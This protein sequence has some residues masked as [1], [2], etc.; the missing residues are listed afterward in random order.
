MDV[1]CL[2]CGSHWPEKKISN[3][4]SQTKCNSPLSKEPDCPY[5]LSIM[6][7][8]IFGLGTNL[9]DYVR[10]NLGPM[11]HEWYEGPNRLGTQLY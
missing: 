11:I 8:E 5:A 7:S 10:T 4:Q 2:V 1:G 3:S 6:S 9:A